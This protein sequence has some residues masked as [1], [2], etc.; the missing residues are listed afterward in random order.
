ML[1]VIQVILDQG[2]IDFIKHPKK[3]GVLSNFS[4]HKVNNGGS[5][6][7][8]MNENEGQLTFHHNNK[9][10]AKFDAGTVAG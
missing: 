10:L 9:F 6:R 1:P 8:I 3:L 4:V 5:K 7:G 2:K